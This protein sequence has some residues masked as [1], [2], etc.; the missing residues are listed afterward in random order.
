M[1]S[2]CMAYPAAA[3]LLDAASGTYRVQI[4]AHLGQL[5][6]FFVSGA[7]AQDFANL[8]TNYGRTGLLRYDQPPRVRA[9]SVW[10]SG[11]ALRR[12]VKARTHAHRSTGRTRPPR[13]PD[14]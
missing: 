9:G 4:S 10:A 11:R 7:H 5:V 6:Q 2:F 8:A 14:R 12:L 13:P 1:I 3:K